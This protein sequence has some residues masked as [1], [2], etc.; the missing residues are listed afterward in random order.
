MLYIYFLTELLILISQVN[1]E[2]D[3]K[4]YFPED[5]LRKAPPRELLLP[6][7]LNRPSS[8]S[9]SLKSLSMDSPECS[10]FLFTP[11][12]S[13]PSKEPPMEQALR[14]IS[15]SIS[16]LHEAT[17]PFSLIQRIQFPTVPENK[18]SAITG[19]T[20]TVQS[21]PSTSSSSHQPPLQNLIPNYPL[22]QKPSSA[23]KRYGLALAPSSSPL[24]ARVRRQNLAKRSITFFRTLGL[25]RIQERVQGSRPTTTQLHHMIAER[26]RREK[27]NDSFQALRS[28]LPPGTKVL[29]YIY[30][31]CVCVYVTTYND[32]KYWSINVKLIFWP[33]NISTPPC[34]IHTK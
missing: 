32:F 24:A 26:K 33:P 20:L 27:L 4:N 22:S 18:D 11:Y 16:P 30:N 28:L 12:L 31:L 19:A 25:M 3:M 15:T 8:S 14:P 9:S 5:F 10:P 23:F 1:L 2:M 29:L 7:D 34:N 21:S 13:E 17:Q 6:T